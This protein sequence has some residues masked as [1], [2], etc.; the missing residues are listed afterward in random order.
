MTDSS[1]GRDAGH[2]EGVLAHAEDAVAPSEI[3]PRGWWAL[4]VRA[5]R[6]VH[7]SRLPFISAG[8]AFFAVLSIAPVLVAALSVYGAVNTPT[9]SLRRLSE[10]AEVLPPEVE[11]TVADQLT[12]ITTASTQVLT[13]R[14]LAGL[15]IALWTATTATLALIDALTVAYHEQETRSFRRRVALALTFVLGGALLLGA[16]I[17]AAGFA[18]RQMDGAP[19]LVRTVVWIAVWTVLAVMMIALLAVLYR[20]APDRKPPRWCWTSWGSAGATVLWI[21]T[22]FALFSYAQTLGTYESIYGSL[23]GVVIS[24]FWLWVTV[25]LIVAGAAVNGEA[26]RQTGRDTTVGRERPLGGRGAV[27]ADSTPAR[28]HQADSEAP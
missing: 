26:E 22:S 12:S 8:V 5:L 17:S 7:D 3:P 18:A 20:F 15:L 4:L 21:V 25:L 16:L 28:L 11:A 1:S 27:V 9:Q 10:I 2:T 19:D 23:A 14:G 6:H 13:V 24:M